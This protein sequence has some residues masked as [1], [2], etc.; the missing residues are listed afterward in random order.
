MADAKSAAL[1]ASRSDRDERV[2]ELFDRA[3]IG[4]AQIDTAGRY[5]LVNE[6]Y[7]QLLERSQ[8]ELLRA[9]IQDF[10]HAD[11]LATSIDAFIGVMESGEPALI[12]QRHV[13]PDGSSR[14]VSN[15][16]SLARPLE[17]QAPYVL[18]LAQDIATLKK[19]EGALL[20]AQSD[21]RMLL[22]AAAEGF[23]CVDREGLA[24]LCNVAFL[25]LLG[26]ER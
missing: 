12:E 5:L 11:D 13:L 14:W 8:G 9:R 18:I 6:R 10:T 2:Q 15:N 17:G 25:R 23:F 4:I 26:Y 22:D 7:C 1:G 20:R 24:T 3:G 21:L 16:A 19:T